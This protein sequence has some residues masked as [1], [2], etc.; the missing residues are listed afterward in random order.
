MS[1]R[2]T[3][4]PW[5]FAFAVSIYL[6]C[7]SMLSYDSYRTVATAISL[8]R[9]GATQVD[10]F[11]AAAPAV[12]YGLE[13]VPES[14]HC[15]N[16]SPAGTSLLAAPIVAAIVVAV[17]VM[18]SLAPQ[19][20]IVIVSMAGVGIAWRRNWRRPLIGWLA[21]IPILHLALICAAWP[22]HGYGPRFTTDVMHLAVLFL[23]PAILWWQT[24][25]GAA[26]RAL[27]GSFLAPSLWRVFVHARGA[28]SPL[29]NLWSASP[30]NVD[31]ARWRMW[32]WNDP[33]FLRGL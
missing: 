15:Y 9:H 2:K 28:A 8:V 1:P 6:I 19:S 26:R 14:G 17:S 32:D 10:E 33:Q 7:P 3:P 31:T 25:T 24:T 29:A 20:P 4:S 21:V 13:C 22:G 30:A 5:L 16:L 23:I 18:G 12:A 11:V 27:S